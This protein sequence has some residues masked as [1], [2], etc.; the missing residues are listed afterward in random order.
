MTPA[1]E[2]CRAVLCTCGCVQAVLRVAMQHLTPRSLHLYA[3]ALL[4]N[5]ADAGAPCTRVRGR[6]LR[7]CTGLCIG[8]LIG[9][10]APVLVQ[11]LASHPG[12]SEPLLYHACSLL[13]AMS[14]HGNTKKRSNMQSHASR[15]CMGFFFLPPLRAG[16]GQCGAGSPWQRAPAHGAGGTH[17]E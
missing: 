13:R 7:A 11:Q 15:R 16:V 2:H 1:D 17:A 3:L 14:A 6:C 9:L 4:T 5:L 8:E 12:A 10:G